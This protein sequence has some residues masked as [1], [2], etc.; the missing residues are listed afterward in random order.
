MTKRQVIHAKIASNAK[1]IH[2]LH[3]KNIELSKEELL[4]SDKQQWYTETTETHGKGKN[5]KE[6]LIGRIN[7]KE[8]FKDE[9][10]GE[11]VTIERSQVVRQNGEWI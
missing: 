1:K 4:L 6:Y 11:V 5:K 3:Q 9:D 8:D 2:A 10:T 7:W